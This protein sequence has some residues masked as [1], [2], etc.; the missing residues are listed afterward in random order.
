VKTM[1]GILSDS[2]ARPRMSAMLLGFFAALSLGLAAIGVYGVLAFAVTQRT[3]EI[4]VRMALGA[5]RSQVVQLFLKQGAMLVLIGAGVGIVGALAAG[6]LLRS[7]LFQ[8]PAADPFSAAIT[9]VVLIAVGIAAV[10]I[11]A[12]RAS[13][14]DPV[15]ALR[16]E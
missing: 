13:K 9:L 7:I 12:R 10:C 11:P 2:L 15:E 14:V 16:A 1:D 6:R 8:T 3:R 4:G 5:E